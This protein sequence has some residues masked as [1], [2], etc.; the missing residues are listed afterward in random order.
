MRCLAAQQPIELLAE[1]DVPGMT[2]YLDSLRWSSDGL[3]PVIVQVQDGHRM[4][5][6]RDVAAAH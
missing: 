2:S 6:L 5:L 1:N 3:I 4:V